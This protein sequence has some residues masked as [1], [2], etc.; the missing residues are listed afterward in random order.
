MTKRN[1]SGPGDVESIQSALDAMQLLSEAST[2]SLPPEK[3][4][5]MRMGRSEVIH[6]W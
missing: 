5:L 4:V 1:I 2:L 6:D 3:T